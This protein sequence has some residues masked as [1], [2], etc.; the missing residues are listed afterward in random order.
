MIRKNDQFRT[1]SDH[2]QWKERELDDVEDE[3]DPDPDDEGEPWKSFST[4]FGFPYPN[5]SPNLS[6][7]FPPSGLSIKA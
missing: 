7:K 1:T 5:P 6:S 4:C 2:I 3:G